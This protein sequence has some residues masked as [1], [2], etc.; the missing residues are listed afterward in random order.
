MHRAFGRMYGAFIKHKRRVICPCLTAIWRSVCLNQGT[1][2]WGGGC[3]KPTWY[4]CRV[5][6][7]SPDGVSDASGPQLGHAALIP[8]KRRGKWSS[9]CIAQD[10]YDG[11]AAASNRPGMYEG[12]SPGPRAVCPMHRTF[13]R[14]LRLSIQHQRRDDWPLFREVLTP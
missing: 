14:G 7:R 9:V 1:I 13:G 3:I 2:R 10:T 12:W 8:H 5:A 6:P 4:V 11:A